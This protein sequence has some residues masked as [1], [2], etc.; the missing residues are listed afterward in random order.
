MEKK[1]DEER[2]RTENILRGNP[3]LNKGPGAA[4]AEPSEFKVKRRYVAKGDHASPLSS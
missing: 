2:I 1:Q 4:A 3:L